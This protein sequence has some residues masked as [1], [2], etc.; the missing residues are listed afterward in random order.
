M[1]DLVYTPINASVE[2]SI[3]QPKQISFEQLL[4]FYGKRIIRNDYGFYPNPPN[5]V[6]TVPAGKVFFLYTASL[7]A[8]D[9]ENRGITPPIGFIEVGLSSGA[10]SRQAILEIRAQGMQDIDDAP[11]VVTSVQQN[12]PIPIRM[13]PGESV[14][15]NPVNEEI[16]LN[17]SF[18]GY[19][20]DSKL[21]EKII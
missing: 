11:V 16:Y 18:F 9:N 20:I 8:Y 14:Y 7:T 17:G 5:A 13:D 21:L 10:T 2:K 6:Y 3:A 1:E 15:I 19:E 12:F 4:L